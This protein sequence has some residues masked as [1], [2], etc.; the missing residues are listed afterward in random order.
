MTV[1]LTF[2]IK[3]EKELENISKY[4]LERLTFKERNTLVITFK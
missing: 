3:L 4:L 2:K 1:S